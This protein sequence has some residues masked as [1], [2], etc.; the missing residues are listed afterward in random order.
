MFWL[1]PNWTLSLS[2]SVTE[3][4]KM[5]CCDGKSTY[6]GLTLRVQDLNLFIHSLDRGS[7]KVLYF[8]SHSFCYYYLL[9]HLY[10]FILYTHIVILY[11]LNIIF[12]VYNS[13]QILRAFSQFI[14]N[15]ILFKSIITIIFRTIFIITIY[16]NMYLY[17]CILYIY[18]CVYVYILI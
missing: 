4:H 6:S 18:M 12:H 3:T 8:L 16:I 2:I 13:Y 1:E 15:D 17:V 5:G 7:W 9:I 11:V 10:L 14:V